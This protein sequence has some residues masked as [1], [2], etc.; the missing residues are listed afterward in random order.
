VN[1]SSFKTT[2]TPNKAH[3]LNGGVASL[4]HIAHQCPAA[5]DARRWSALCPSIHRTL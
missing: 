2:G 3:A 4:F 1:T 5:S